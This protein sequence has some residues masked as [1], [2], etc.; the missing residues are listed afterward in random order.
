MPPPPVPRSM[1]SAEE[2]MELQRELIA[3]Y[4][5]H[6]PERKPPHPRPSSPPEPRGTV[7][8]VRPD[9]EWSAR[10]LKKA[11][12]LIRAHDQGGHKGC[13]E[14]VKFQVKMILDLCR[15]YYFRYG[16]VRDC[17]ENTQAQ[18]EEMCLKCFPNE[19]F[20]YRNDMWPGDR[21]SVLLF[22]REGTCCVADI[23]FSAQVWM[24]QQI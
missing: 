24:A 4:F 18:F 12:E 3:T 1:L 13:N 11:A 9:F 8:Y 5:P 20:L 10:T 2:S 19:I 16:W 14:T 22:L 23:L 21:V 15:N 7:V 17:P 6:P